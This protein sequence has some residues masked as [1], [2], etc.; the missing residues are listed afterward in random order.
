MTLYR[1]YWKDS[2]GYTGFTY[3]EV[4]DSFGR[5]KAAEARR[6]FKEQYGGEIIK[7]VKDC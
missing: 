5:K 2:D 4:P 1:V 7:V 6:I 3:I